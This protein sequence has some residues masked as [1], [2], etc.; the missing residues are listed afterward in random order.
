[1]QRMRYKKWGPH[2]LVEPEP[3]YEGEIII[4]CENN[5]DK[6]S[7]DQEGQRKSASILRLDL[8]SDKRT[9]HFG[10]RGRTTTVSPVKSKALSA[11]PRLSHSLNESTELVAKLFWPEDA[12]QSEPEVL[13]EVYKI[14]TQ[15]PDV[16]GHVP[17]MV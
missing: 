7:H 1:M 10:L 14:A 13:E 15:D 8:R 6:D 9:T 2:P 16:L 12:R 17:D 5:T 4:E 11:L 3:G